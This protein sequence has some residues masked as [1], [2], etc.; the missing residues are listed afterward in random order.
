MAFLAFLVLLCLALLGLLFG[1]LEWTCLVW[2]WTFLRLIIGVFEVRGPD[3]EILSIR[4]G[5]AYRFIPVF[6]AIQKKIAKLRNIRGS[7]RSSELI[8]RHYVTASLYTSHFPP[9]NAFR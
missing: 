3:V 1:C 9:R 4:Q 7:E 8:I 2:T 6:A 5:F